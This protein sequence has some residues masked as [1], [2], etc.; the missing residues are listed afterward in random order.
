MNIKDN[1][2][3]RQAARS[4]KV[5]PSQ[6]VWSKLEHKLENT[7]KASNSFIYRKWM[8]AA[9]IFFIVACSL[10]F[11][12][13]SSETQLIP[14][15][16]MANHYHLDNFD[17]D[18]HQSDGIYQLDKLRSLNKAYEQLSLKNNM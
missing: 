11:F 18:T 7:P 12:I 9:A 15:I 13:S 16:S 2:H 8:Y 6:K 1:N 17:T 10:L 4:Y 3:L 5:Q 14:N